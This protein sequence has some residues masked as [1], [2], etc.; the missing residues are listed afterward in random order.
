M[1]TIITK[2]PDKTKI[3][4][5]PT[6]EEVKA[7]L[8]MEPDFP[9]V[10]DTIITDN[11]A[12]AMEMVEDDTNSDVQDT[13]NVLEINVP[14]GVQT[15]NTIMQSP[16][17]SFTRLEAY[18][19][20]WEEVAAAKYEIEK[21]FNSFKVVMLESI[22]ATKLRFTFKTG[23]TADKLPKTLKKAV[24]IKAADLYDTERSDYA[25]GVTNI[26]TYQRLISKHI[27]NYW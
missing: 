22:T 5:S 2:A 10:D 21:G 17:Q 3:F 26:K 19:G 13:V 4:T 15:T 20:E 6:I 25:A 11:L 12:T 16:L 24:I 18:N 8:N 23:Y 27:R 9:D 1:S 7:Q 14:S